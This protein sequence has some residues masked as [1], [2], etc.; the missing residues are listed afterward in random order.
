M[1]QETRQ[2]IY[3]QLEILKKLDPDN[4]ADYKVQQEIVADGYTSRYS[5]VLT[6]SKEEVS[7]A[8]QQEVYD[9]LE[10]FRALNTALKNGWAPENIEAAKFRGYD[11]NNHDE[12]YSFAH[13]ILDVKHLFDES[14]PMRNSHNIA[15]VEKYRRMVAVWKT[16]AVTYELTNAEAEA[17]IA[18]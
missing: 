2:I 14:A 1:N 16:S 4:A 10:M 17:I 9:T 8:V 11:G 12:H 5:E 3:N 18:A 7:A 13:H 15:S 6:V